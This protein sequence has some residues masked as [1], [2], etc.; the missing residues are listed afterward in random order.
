MSKLPFFGR[1][2]KDRHSRLFAVYEL[3]VHPEGLLI[4]PMNLRSTHFKPVWWPVGT[5]NVVV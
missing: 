5:R 2:V 4:P 1:A 3:P